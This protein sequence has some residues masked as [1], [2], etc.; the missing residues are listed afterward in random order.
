MLTE[1]AGIFANERLVLLDQPGF[2]ERVITRLGFDVAG[3]LGFSLTTRQSNLQCCCA[4]AGGTGETQRNKL[5][6]WW[7]P[8]W[9]AGASVMCCGAPP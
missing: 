7:Q 9:N 6:R 2:R 4:V 5:T 1:A 8:I 3:T